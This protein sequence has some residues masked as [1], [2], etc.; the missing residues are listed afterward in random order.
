MSVPAALSPEAE[1]AECEERTARGEVSLAALLRACASEADQRAFRRH[2]EAHSPIASLGRLQLRHAAHLDPDAVVTALEARG[3]PEACVK[4][5]ETLLW[6]YEDTLFAPLLEPPLLQGQAVALAMRVARRRD[7]VRPG[8]IALADLPLR[9]DAAA[10]ANK[11]EPWCARYLDLSANPLQGDDAPGI[12]EAVKALCRANGEAGPLTVNLCANKLKGEAAREL[13]VALAQTAGVGLVA[14]RGQPLASDSLLA[15]DLRDSGLLGK[16]S[17]SWTYITPVGLENNPAFAAVYAELKDLDDAQRAQVASA[18]AAFEA[19]RSLALS[20]QAAA[21][22]A[23][24][25]LLYEG[26]GQVE[27]PTKQRQ[28]GICARPFSHVSVV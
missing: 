10:Q 7:A 13:I 9:I 21:H 2:A 28:A 26:H 19:S 12:L 6:R 24:E 4:G 17:A 8:A 14:I 18:D 20:A 22:Q 16:V 5:M 11:G 1:K 27:S 25:D 23:L 3:V 15:R